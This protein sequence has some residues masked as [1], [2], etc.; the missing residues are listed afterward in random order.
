MAAEP[1][2]GPPR[3]QWM[4]L[5]GGY[6]FLPEGRRTA[7]D[8]VVDVT[9]SLIAIGI[10]SLALASTWESHSAMSVAVD[11]AIGA[12]AWGGLWMR[13][14]HP[15]ALAVLACLASIISASAAGPATIAAF[16][17]ALRCTRRQVAVVVLLGLGSAVFSPLVYSSN[18]DY[19]VQLVF[20]I[21]CTFVVVGWGLFVRARREVVLSLRERAARLEA[22]QQ[23][24][25]ERARATERQRIAREM[26]DVLAH[27]ISL[28]ALHAGALE[29]RPDAPAAEVAHAAGV[30]RGSAHAAL[31]ELRDAVGLLR[32]DDADREPEPPQPTLGRLPELIEESRAAGMRVR[33][34]IDDTEVPELLGRTAY[35]IVQE[36]LT[37]ARKHAPDAAVDVSVAAGD[38]LVV[39]V[40]S[41][42]PVGRTGIPGAGAGLIGLTERVSLAGGELEHGRDERGDFVLR[43]RLPL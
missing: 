21:L 37:N 17:G 33:A 24:H 26:H 27:R 6:G 5:P 38:A 15:F 8:W 23:L 30:I 2:A 9:L 42:R 10:G 28:L 43:A 19:V 11:L 39:E 34:K 20:G 41:R 31:E 25:L 22:E 36:G 13:R 14:S 16:N 40:I 29:F 4:L 3:W 32:T 35:R 7:R 18:D 1:T 12:A